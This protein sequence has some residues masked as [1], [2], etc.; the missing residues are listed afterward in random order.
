MKLSTYLAQH[1]LSPAAF[2]VR[3]GVPASTISRILNG[4]R[5]PRLETIAKI[6]AVTDGAVSVSDFVE[7]AGV[8]A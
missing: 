5:T 6:A 2:A 7:T 4:Q 3:V 1:E 8:A